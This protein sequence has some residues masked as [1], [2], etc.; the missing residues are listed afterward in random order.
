MDTLPLLFFKY[1]NSLIS[2]FT[3]ERFN[4]IL[5]LGISFITFQSLSYFFEVRKNKI[6]VEKN[7]ITVFLYISFFPTISSGPIQRP[8]NLIPQLKTKHVF[9]YE[10]A[11]NGMRLFAWGAFK[12]IIISNSLSSYVDAVYD[13]ASHAHC[14][15]VLLATIFYSFQI[16]CD[17]SGYSDMAIGLSNFIGFDVGKNFCHPYL[18]KSCSE[19]WKKWHISLSSWLRD[20][21]YIPLGG[22]RV[23]SSRIYINLVITFLVSGIWHGAA[24]TFVLWGLIHG[25]YQCIGRMCKST[26]EKFPSYIRVLN[27][28]MIIS[29]SWIFFRANTLED[30]F[31]LIK[32]VFNIPYE[33]FSLHTLISTLG[34]KDSIRT[35]FE[36]HN[37]I[38][39]LSM[40]LKL[41]VFILLDYIIA[42]NNGFEILKKQTTA[43]RWVIYG[44]LIYILEYSLLENSI[45]SISTNFIYQNF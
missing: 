34:L 22:S 41:F 9:N 3:N 31:I 12:K 36:I 43:V 17:F 16:Y 39:F 1:I 26:N 21:I 38:K 14:C 33:L 24:W 11:T 35:I 44:L 20:Y 13:N 6:G 19:F 27:T 8:E 15:A 10:Q 45:S 23:S 37:S 28:F 7:P 18:S 32:K 42:K 5:P 40:V 2:P 25:L 29:F 30:C 4:T